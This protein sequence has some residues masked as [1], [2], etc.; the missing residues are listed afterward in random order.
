MKCVGASASKGAAARID[1]GYLENVRVD[2]FIRLS[3]VQLKPHTHLLT[4][5]EKSLR[6]ILLLRNGLQGISTQISTTH[7]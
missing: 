5:V 4:R 3:S 1:L 7:S 6:P 2:D